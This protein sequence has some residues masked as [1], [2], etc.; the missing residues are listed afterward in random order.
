MTWETT[1]A[2]LRLAAR[3]HEPRGIAALLD[4]DVR[5][6]VTVYNRHTHKIQALRKI[7]LSANGLESKTS[8]ATVSAGKTSA[9]VLKFGR[10]SGT[11]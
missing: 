1:R 10:G 9:N 2:I 7:W 5:Q 3:G 4:L 6:V 8:R 11:R